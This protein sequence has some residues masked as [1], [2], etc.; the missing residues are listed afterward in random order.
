MMMTRNC[1]DGVRRDALKVVVDVVDACASC[2]V[3]ENADFTTPVRGVCRLV[4]LLKY[5]CDVILRF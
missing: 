5:F 3:N 4:W 2:F 1:A